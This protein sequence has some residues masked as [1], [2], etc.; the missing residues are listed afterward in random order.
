MNPFR[1]DK[2]EYGQVIN[3]IKRDRQNKRNNDI[4]YTNI[5]FA[6]ILKQHKQNDSQRAYSGNTNVD[7]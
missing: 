3:T 6:A 2:A 5:L 7:G 4:D 1:A